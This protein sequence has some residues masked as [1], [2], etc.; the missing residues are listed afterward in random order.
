MILGNLGSY[1]F[2]DLESN[3][4]SSGKWITYKFRKD[5]Y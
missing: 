3:I 1:L 2:N 5:R 4:I